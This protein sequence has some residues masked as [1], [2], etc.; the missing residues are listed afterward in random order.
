[1]IS[2]KIKRNISKIDVPD[3]CQYVSDVKN[4]NEMIED[5]KIHLFDMMGYNHLQKQICNLV[6]ELEVFKEATK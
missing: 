1:M 2:E 4:V 3:R 5:L 6:H